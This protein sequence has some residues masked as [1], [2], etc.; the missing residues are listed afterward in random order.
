MTASQAPSP[1]YANVNTTLLAEVPA[2]ARRILEL[3]CGAGALARAIKRQ[4]PQVFYAGVELMA[5]PLAQASEVLDVALLRNL[6]QVPN[7]AADAQMHESLPVGNFDLVIMGDVLEHLYEPEAVLAQ[8]VRR[9]RPEGHALVC[10][11]NVQHWSVLA[12]LMVGH[13]PR[14]DSGLFDRTH[15]RWFTLRDMH[16]LLTGCGLKVQKVVPRVFQPE[17]GQLLL[18]A[19][20]PALRV[21]NVDPRQFAQLALPLQYVLVGQKA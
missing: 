20:E 19:L 5:E 9:L 16:A 4:C 3:G 21:L 6:D 17:Q 10:I 2:S 15:V 7:W 13:W 1:Y 14:T 8:A 18:Q 12:Q 11:P